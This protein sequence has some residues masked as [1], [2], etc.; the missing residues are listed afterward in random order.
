MT[1]N[2]KAP[3]V[4][5]IMRCHR[6]MMRQV[7]N[8][9]TMPEADIEEMNVLEQLCG[10]FDTHEILNDKITALQA[11]IEWRKKAYSELDDVNIKLNE[12]IAKMKEAYGVVKKRIEVSNYFLQK[13]P[14][15]TSHFE[16]CDID[17]KE[18]GDD[19]C[20]CG[21]DSFH[22]DCHLALSINKEALAK[23]EEILK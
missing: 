19:C 4:E 1:P 18:D 11:E 22:H 15:F 6:L 3:S 16:D 20:D 17:E 10:P 2:D 7:C 5:Q 13:L 12:Q 8:Q 21:L 23:A 9:E 14:T